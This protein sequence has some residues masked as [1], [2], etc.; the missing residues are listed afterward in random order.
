MILCL[1]PNPALDRTLVVPDLRM[2][3]VNRAT[4]VIA[5]AGGKGLNVAR[6]IH[7]LGGDPLCAGF[8]G[9]STGRLVAQL[10]SEEEMQGLWTW[11][12]GETR[13]CL[14][15]VD[16]RSREATVINAPGPA[17]TASDWRRWQSDVLPEAT[18]AEH[19]CLSG[20]LPPGAPLES[21]AGFL[22]ALCVNGRP[23]WVDTSGEAL[24]CALAVGGVNIKVNAEE[25]GEVLGRSIDD[26][27]AALSAATE[28]CERSRAESAIITLG[29]RGAVVVRDQGG[30]SA[31]APAIQAVSG[32]GS[33][34]SFL[35]GWVTGLA[36]GKSPPEAL[37]QAI[38]AGAAN[39]LATSGG[40]FNLNDLE[41]LL[42]ATTVTRHTRT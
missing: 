27:A 16:P 42:R 36:D 29:G 12:E 37:R 26:A 25:A 14:I 10:A 31:M 21:F 20:S 34:D 19:I 13:T 1:T 32:V 6:A 24:R 18:R 17:V 40:T 23:L 7:T 38:A 2:G 3:E 4:R 30:W 22:R 39:A 41:Q 5:A 35:A 9:G 33:G 8:L 15:V 28:L 11:I